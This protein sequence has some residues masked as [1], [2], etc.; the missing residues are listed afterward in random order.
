MTSFMVVDDETGFARRFLASGNKAD[1]PG[2]SKDALE[3]SGMTMNMFEGE[4][5]FSLIAR[6][7]GS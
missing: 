4:L 3:R 7:V 5:S 2:V 6:A 1:S